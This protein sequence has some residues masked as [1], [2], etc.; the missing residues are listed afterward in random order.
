MPAVFLDFSL[1]VEAG[2]LAEP[3]ACPYSQ[4]TSQPASGL[5]VLISLPSECWGY[6]QLRHPPALLSFYVGSGYP[7]V[8]ASHLHDKNFIHHASSPAQSHHSAAHKGV[9]LITRYIAL[10]ELANAITFEIIILKD[11]SCFAASETQQL[12]RNQSPK[13]VT[14]GLKL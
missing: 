9:I 4:P 7:V 6:I 2:S 1:S 8:W 10:Q 11:I 5:L 14:D 13:D 3:R 12:I